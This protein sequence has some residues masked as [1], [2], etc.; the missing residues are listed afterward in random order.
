MT[1]K[2]NKVEREGNIDE[3]QSKE[4]HIRRAKVKVAGTGGGRGG[5]EMVRQSAG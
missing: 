3:V 5:G 1:R 4:E 2:K